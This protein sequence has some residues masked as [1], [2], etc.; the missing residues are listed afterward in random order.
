MLGKLAIMGVAV[1]GAAVGGAVGLW[2]A[3]QSYDVDYNFLPLFYAPAGALVGA[4]LGTVVGVM[5][6]T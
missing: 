4:L 3:D 5:V 2:R 6:F 1:L